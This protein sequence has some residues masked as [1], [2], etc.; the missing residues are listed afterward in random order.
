[1]AFFGRFTSMRG[2]VG[3]LPISRALPVAGRR[4]IGAWCFMDHAGPATAD[5]ALP[6]DAHFE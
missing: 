3:G 6:L 1:M 5:T 2:E 4:T